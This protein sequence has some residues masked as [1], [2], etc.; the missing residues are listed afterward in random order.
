MGWFQK[1]N[2]RVEPAIPFGG[3][4]TLTAENFGSAEK[5]Y[6]KTL[7]D[8]VISPALEDKMIASAGIMVQNIL[9]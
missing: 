1:A 7:Q 5:V 2:Y 3:K 9:N 6:I 8:I 4:I